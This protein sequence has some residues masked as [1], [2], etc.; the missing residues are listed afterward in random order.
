MLFLSRKLGESI[1]I[2]DNIELVVTEIRGKT[3]KLGFTFPK[4]A[5]ILR[6]ELYD[7]IAAENLAAKT[8]DISPDD[9]TDALTGVSKED[10]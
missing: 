4:N 8:A 10:E 6:K 5:S 9:F 1:I 2:N 3:V 7:K